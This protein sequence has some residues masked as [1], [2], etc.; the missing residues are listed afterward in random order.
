MVSMS[1]VDPE[2]AGQESQAVP[3]DRGMLPRIRPG[4]IME[5][6]AGRERLLVAVQ[7]FLSCGAI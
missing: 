4:A 2:A 1:R 5:R 6:Q 3:V 7:F